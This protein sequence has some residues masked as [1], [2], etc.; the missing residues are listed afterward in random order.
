MWLLPIASDRAGT[1]GTYSEVPF[2]DPDDSV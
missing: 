1:A 2:R